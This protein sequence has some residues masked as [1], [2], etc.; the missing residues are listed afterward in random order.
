MDVFALRM[1]N[2]Y[3]DGFNFSRIAQSTLNLVKLN[4]AQSNSNVMKKVG[5]RIA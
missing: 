4:A 2:E 5:N 3:D 1:E